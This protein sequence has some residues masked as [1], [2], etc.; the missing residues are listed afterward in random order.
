MK[1]RGGRESK[2][3]EGRTREE[4]RKEK[5]S[6]DETNCCSFGSADN[7]SVIVIADGTP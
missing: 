4:R 6:A 3:K 5:L 1:R 7:S 2:R